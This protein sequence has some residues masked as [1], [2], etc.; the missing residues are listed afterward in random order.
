M[1]PSCDASIQKSIDRIG[2]AQVIS[3]RITSFREVALRMDAERASLTEK[4]PDKWVAVGKDG[5]IAVSDS[6]EDLFAKVRPLGLHNSE[7]DVA[8]LDT[9]PSEMLF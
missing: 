5:L 9:D 7:Y 8:F 3:A 2:G 1:K 6:M 4:Y